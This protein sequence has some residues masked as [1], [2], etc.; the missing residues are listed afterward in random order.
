MY[1]YN[2][3]LKGGNMMVVTARAIIVEDEGL[4]VFYREKLVDGERSKYYALPGG[5]VEKGETSEETVVRE[6]KEELGIGIVVEKKVGVIEIDGKREEYFLCQ[7][8][9]GEPVLGGEE[10]LRNNKDNYYEFRYLP[11]VQ[12]DDSGIR[13]LDL[14]KKVLR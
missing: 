1:D 10:L 4:M 12:L 5:H 13:A 7:R 6:L 9:S 14:V 8:V 2:S 11:V 3:N